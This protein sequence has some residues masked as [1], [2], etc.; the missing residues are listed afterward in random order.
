MIWPN[1]SELVE[2]FNSGELSAVENV[3]KAFEL[4]EKGNK[5]NAIISVNKEAALS[6]AKELD[7][8]RSSGEKLGKLAGVPYIAKDNFLTKELKTTAASNMLRDYQ[9]NYEATAIKLLEN[10]GAIMVAKANLDAFAHGTSTENSD[11]FT[12]ANPIDIEYV[13]GGSSGGSA[14]SVALDMAPFA[15]GTDTGGS[16]RLPASFCGIVGY[17]PTYGSVSRSGVVAMASSLDTIGVLTK[18]VSDAA[19]VQEVMTA[20]D[21]LDS[22][23]IDLEDKEFSK[24]DK[25]DKK[26]KI[27][28]LKEH[29][30]GEMDPNIKQGIYAL[31]EKLKSEGH[32]VEEA[33]IPDLPLALAVYYI[34]C[35]AEVASNLSRYDGIRYGHSAEENKDLEDFYLNSRSEGFGAEAKRRIMIGTHVLS[36]GYFDAYYNK[37]QTVRTRL[38]NQFNDAFTKY[39]FLIGPTSPST[40]FKIGEKSKDPLAMYLMD[41]MTVATNLVGIPAI[42]VPAGE[43]NGMPYGVHIMANLKKDHDLFKVSKIVEDLK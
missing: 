41:I 7:E 29:I 2:K 3:N 34:V 24:L 14:A 36:S 25:S 33:S 1:I 43:S 21:P 20:R 35:P 16:I 26:Y 18:N 13:A 32:Q 27:G 6:R 31:I 8:R 5:Y 9:A 23:T 11:F 30:E 42:S 15:L 4:I 37:A 17:K 28:L 19:I 12:T 38:I 22:T 39:D 10:E 40:A